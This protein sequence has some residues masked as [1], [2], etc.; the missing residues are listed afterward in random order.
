MRKETKGHLTIYRFSSYTELLR[1]MT[2][3]QGLDQ[4]AISKAFDEWQVVIPNPWRG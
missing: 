4:I 3:A 2:A 1:W